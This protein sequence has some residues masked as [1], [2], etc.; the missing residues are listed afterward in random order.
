MIEFGVIC[1]I[2][3]YGSRPTRT[4]GGHF[5]KLDAL[6]RREGHRP[7]D[8]PKYNLRAVLAGRFLIKAGFR[9]WVEAG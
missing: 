1:S 2:Y 5:A 9:C 6:T 3:G 8:L 7:L 4:A